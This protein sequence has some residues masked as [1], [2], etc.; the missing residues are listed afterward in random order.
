MRWSD[1]MAKI[2]EFIRRRAVPAAGEAA[3]LTDFLRGFSIEVMPRTAATI[4]DFR[5]I[6]PQGTRVY[7][8]HID[9]TETSEMVATCRRLVDEGFSV[10]PHVPARGLASRAELEARLKAYA[11]VGVSEALAI[12]GGLAVPRGPFADTMSMLETGLFDRSGFTRLHVAGH[13]EGNRDIDPAGGVAEVTAALRRKNAFQTRTDARM[14]IVTQFAFEPEPVIAWA[15]RLREE[16][17]TL[18]IFVGVAG[19]AKLQTMIR[20]AMACGVGPSLR[21]LQRRATDLANLILPFEPTGVLAAL[22]RHK[23]DHPDSLVEAAH[24]FPLGG[25]SATTA[26]TAGAAAAT[27]SRARA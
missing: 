25:I 11:D 15:E 1:V 12:A 9:G 8:A 4:D 3:N 6:L 23:A 16:E 5:A 27:S 22:A 13:P 14:A 19:P 24:F 21:V 2:L 17:I 26:Y 7:V 18:P 10:M 20:F